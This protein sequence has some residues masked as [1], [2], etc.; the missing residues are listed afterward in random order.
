MNYTIQIDKRRGSKSELILI[1]CP[2]KGR[3]P[4]IKVFFRALPKRGAGM[5][6]PELFN[7]NCETKQYSVKKLYKIRELGGGAREVIP[8]LPIKTFFSGGVP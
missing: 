3:P 6:L 7:T 2:C 4:E 1:L 8:A 5:P